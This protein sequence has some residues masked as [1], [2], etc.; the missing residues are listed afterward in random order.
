MKVLIVDDKPENLYLLKILL[1]SKGYEPIIPAANGREALEKLHSE[2]FDLII[3]DIL[4]PVMD[5]FQ[6]C[7]LCKGDD[8]LKTIP[9]VF[10]TATYVDEKD[11]VFA[12]KIGADLFLRKPMAPDKFVQ[13]IADLIEVT[14]RGRLTPSD[15]FQMEE[16]ET[17]KHYSERLVK[18]LEKKMQDLSGELVQR[19]KMEKDLKIRHEISTIFLTVPEETMYEKVLDLI[20]DLTASKY[21]MFGYIDEA[22]D[23][24]CPSLTKEVWAQC[25]IPDKTIAFPRDKWGG[26]WGKAMSERTSLYINHSLTLPE[27]HITIDNA[28][29]VPILYQKR[30]V[31]NFLVGQNEKGYD[32]SEVTMLETISDHVAPILSARLARDV[33]SRER[34][35]A[36]DRLLQAQ[37][38]ESIGILAGGVAH[39]INNPI[40]GI[41]N[42]AQ[43][44]KDKTE[45]NESINEFADEI[46]RETERVAYI[47]KNLLT[48][49]REEKEASSPARI[50]D[51]VDQSIS[52]IQTVIKSDQIS[53]KVDVPGDLPL[54]KC[55]GQQI[56]Q[57]LMNLAT[58]ARDA[59]NDRYKGFDENKT[60]HISAKL[61]EK[62]GR[63]WIR[64]SVMDH[65]T[66]I[67][68][69]TMKNIFDPFFTTKQREVG[70]GLGLSISY[71]IVMD[72]HGELHVESEPGQYTT[73]HM[74]LPVDNDLDSEANDN[75]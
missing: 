41:M 16:E 60:I 38:L 43:L 53:L 12:K 30:L 28:L 25:Q 3:S 5:G 75:G 42:Y 10:Y 27:G 67:S 4:M 19:K 39:E 49:A 65:G 32:Q 36:E 13:S 24:V 23:W 50:K 40:N 22:G 64:T 7:R 15:P 45:L 58:N 68:A 26:I 69:D 57:A 71:G 56:Q 35:K 1:A 47:V 51:I 46:I 9:F 29:D 31:G 20:L 14:Q 66:G 33:E 48:F 8:A 74:D 21:G 2:P 63:R 72:H 55:R 59:L 6:L 44:I 37:K 62:E 70:T 73:F 54:I 34:K 11:E 52:L 18:K 17:Y 61:F